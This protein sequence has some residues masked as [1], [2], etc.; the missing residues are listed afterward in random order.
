[1]DKL[2]KARHAQRLI[3]DD[4]LQDAFREADDNFVRAWRDSEKPEQR[5]QLWYQ[6]HALAEVQRVLRSFVDRAAVEEH[7][8]KRKD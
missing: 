8:L 5:E 6:L 1:M 7:R 3:D 4:V 2:E